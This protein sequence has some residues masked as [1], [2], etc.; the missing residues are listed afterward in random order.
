MQ[1]YNNKRR[2]MSK[3]QPKSKT[4]RKGMTLVEVVIVAIT[5]PFAVIVFDTLFHSMLSDIP[6]SCRLVEENTTL[7]A[8]LEQMQQDISAA[9]AL[10]KSSGQYTAGEGLLLIELADGMVS[11][12]L[13]SGKM[14][15]HRFTEPQK[16]HDE[17]V[18]VWSLPNAKVQW[19]IWQ[20]DSNAYAVEVRTA[21]RYKL[22]SKYQD[23][24]ANS[25]LYFIGSIPEG[26]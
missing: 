23:R 21:I 25:H 2:T 26:L 14:F 18:R 6:R 20:K 12:E 22:R 15:R 1:V 4:M 13:A 17:E 16:G 10:P 8:V 11:Y 9:K 3:E 7:L 24:M 5:L 19:R